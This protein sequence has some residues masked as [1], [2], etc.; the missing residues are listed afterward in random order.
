MSK[1]EYKELSRYLLSKIERVPEFEEKLGITYENVSIKVGTMFDEIN[2][3]I[4][5]DVR[6]VDKVKFE[7][8]SMIVTNV[9]FYDEDNYIL[10][11]ASDAF[12]VRDFL[13]YQTLRLYDH[14][15]DFELDEIAKIRILPR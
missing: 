4:F 11:M 1:N 8:N 12:N 13:G 15:P 2:L 9:T 6:L 14:A 7:K 5:A 10:D 3:T